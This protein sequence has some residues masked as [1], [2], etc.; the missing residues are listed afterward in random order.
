[1]PL[2]L[3][4][5]SHKLRADRQ[6]VMVAVEGDGDALEFASEELRG[7][8]EVVSIALEHM[9]PGGDVLKFAS[10]A[11]REDSELQ[12]LQAQA[13]ERH[14]EWLAKPTSLAETS[15]VDLG[16]TRDLLSLLEDFSQPDSPTS[17]C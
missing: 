5:A 10:E 2:L 8:R 15:N 6:F 9:P 7:D 4:Q 3:K 14:E 12:L 16:R 1:M 17:P 13:V 11:L